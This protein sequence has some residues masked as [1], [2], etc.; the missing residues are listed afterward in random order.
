[1]D[2]IS[3]FIRD[4]QLHERVITAEEATS[5]V[6][7]GM[8][9]GLSGF[10]KAGDAKAVPHALIE[11][12][13]KHPFKVNVFT[14]ASLGSNIDTKMA[15]VGMVHKRMPFQAERTMRQKINKGEI[16]FV[17]SHLS[18]MAEYLRRG[19]L[20]LIDVA[21]IEALAI[22]E[23]GYII[24]TTSVGNSSL[25]VEHAQQIIVEINRAQP[26]ALEGIHDVYNVGLQGK[27]RQ[28]ILINDVS[29]RIGKKGIKVDK[30]RI[31]GIVLTD[32]P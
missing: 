32:Q 30:D 4:K 24:P 1:M 26:A 25:F 8:T 12:A 10:T 28:P 3:T 7:D 20:G 2:Q 6:K 9:L 13:K 17:D 22:T 18:H 5:F 16:L 11:R 21:I 19:E 15:E 14:G 31:V 23:D 29:D 27:A